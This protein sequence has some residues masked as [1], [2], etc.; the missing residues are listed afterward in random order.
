MLCN[1]EILKF[2][3]QIQKLTEAN[4]ETTLMLKEAVAVAEKQNIE[5][6][7]LKKVLS[8][9]DR[10]NEDREE[11]FKKSIE[12]I[13]EILHEAINTEAKQIQEELQSLKK[14]VNLLMINNLHL[15]SGI[16]FLECQCSIKN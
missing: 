8:Q 1:F 3:F 16:N 10:Q 12:S 6:N 7:L 9:K 4:H 11:K 15:E 2:K 13:N 14:Q 5:I